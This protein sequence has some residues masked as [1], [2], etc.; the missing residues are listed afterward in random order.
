MTTPEKRP[1]QSER[2]KVLNNL[3]P[4]ATE[5]QKRDGWIFDPKYLKKISL[6]T[7]KHEDCP[8][9]MQLEDIEIVLL[10]LMEELRKGE[11]GKGA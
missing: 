10:A 4:E 7:E 2:D 5:K 8:D 1:I 6:I 9:G 11:Q 3:I